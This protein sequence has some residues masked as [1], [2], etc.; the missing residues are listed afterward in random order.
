MIINGR[1]RKWR[2]GVWPVS[3]VECLR[4]RK[5]IIAGNSNWCWTK[6]NSK[7]DIL[8]LH[9]AYRSGLRQKAKWSCV[10]KEQAKPVLWR[11]APDN[12]LLTCLIAFWEDR[13]RLYSGDWM[14]WVVC[15]DPGR[16]TACI[17]DITNWSLWLSVT[18]GV[19]PS[20]PQSS[21][22][23]WTQAFF[24]VYYYTIDSIGRSVSLFLNYEEWICNRFFKMRIKS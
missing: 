8:K 11:P 18:S 4:L 20:R 5:S 17:P 21:E 7:P 23:S 16:D 9:T 2:C 15:D 24:V 13:V 22:I 12:P 19:Q 3:I 10:V 6:Q 14:L 1:K